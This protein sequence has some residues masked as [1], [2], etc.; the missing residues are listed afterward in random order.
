MTV[1][2]F[3]LVPYLHLLTRKALD[4]RVSAMFSKTLENKAT[5][6]K[7]SLYIRWFYLSRGVLCFNRSTVNVSC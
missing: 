6:L 2:A 4:K 7:A 1:N 3:L 5:A